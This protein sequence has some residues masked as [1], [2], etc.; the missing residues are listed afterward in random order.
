M[1]RPSIQPP[2]TRHPIN[3]V[4]PDTRWTSLS[5]TGEEFLGYSVQK[6]SH[7][8]YTT[9]PQTP[10]TLTIDAGAR[11]NA[12]HQSISKL[13]TRTLIAY[14]VT[15][16]ASVHL[17]D[18]HARAS[19]PVCFPDTVA[20]QGARVVSFAR[21]HELLCATAG[22]V[23]VFDI[24]GSDGILPILTTTLHHG[25][26]PTLLPNCE[27]AA[28]QKQQSGTKRHKASRQQARSR[29][30]DTPGTVASSNAIVSVATSPVTGHVYVVRDSGAFTVYYCDPHG[31]AVAGMFLKGQD[32]VLEEYESL[33]RAWLDF[34]M[35][36]RD[37]VATDSCG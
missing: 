13:G 32:K 20:D 2:L 5:V 30:R 1:P 29:H 19:H 9:H 17:Y 36:F 24:G 27:K 18:V 16:D 4:P 21:G 25:P 12:S 22:A 8:Y 37:G 31:V 11:V 14:I 26:A 7:V 3:Q 10:I 23:H 28:P 35:P 33:A 6:R 15:T 34:Q